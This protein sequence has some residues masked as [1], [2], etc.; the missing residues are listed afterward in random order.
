MGSQRTREGP[1]TA[2]AAQLARVADQMHRHVHQHQVVLPGA[3]RLDRSGTILD[4]VDRVP[5]SP[6]SAPRS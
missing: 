3:H 2:A 5:A 1:A 6:A 4:H